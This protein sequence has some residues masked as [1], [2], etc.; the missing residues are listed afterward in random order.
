MLE[1]ILYDGMIGDGAIMFTTGAIPILAERA[2][3]NALKTKPGNIRKLIVGSGCAMTTTGA[4]MMLAPIAYEIGN[5]VSKLI[6]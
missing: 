2:Y 4:A 6:N 1:K 3:A 5:L